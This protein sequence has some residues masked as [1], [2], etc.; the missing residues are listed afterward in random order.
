M[1]TKDKPVISMNFNLDFSKCKTTG[2]V[3]KVFAKVLPIIENAKEKVKAELLEWK[4]IK[5][6]EESGEK[7]EKESPKIYLPK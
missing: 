6:G 5:E 2:D 7:L 1:I 3:D 4:N